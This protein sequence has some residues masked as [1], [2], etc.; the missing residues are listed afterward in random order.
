MFKIRWVWAA[1]VGLAM[2]SV[3]GT[4]LVSSGQPL[5]TDDTWLHWA[6]GRAH[7]HLGPWLPE[8]P[9]LAQALGPPTP[10]A[11][12]FDLGIFGVERTGGFT[13]LRVVHVLF[14]VA[15]LGLA[16]ALYRRARADFLLAGLAMLGFVSLS[17]YRLI[18]LRPHLLTLFAALAL[19]ALVIDRNR[20]P[21]FLRG[22]LAVLLL[23]LWA[24]SH[25]G[26][27]LGFLMLG[28]A[29]LSLIVSL[30][31]RSAKAFQADGPRLRMWWAVGVVG[32]C[33]SLL[34]PA[35]LEPH[36]AWFVAGEE[37][38]SL[39]R[40][41][42]EWVRF[43][44]FRRPQSG[45]PPSPVVWS[46]QWLLM[47][48]TIAAGLYALRSWNQERRE[49]AAGPAIDP[50]LL[51][52]ALLSLALPFIAIRFLWLGIFPLLLF[53]QAE[54]S[55]QE[56]KFSSWHHAR[57]WVLS[58]LSVVLAFAFFQAGPW[59]M[60]R[61]SLPASWTGYQQPYPS[62]KYHAQLIWMA[63]DAGLEGTAFADYHIAN[64][65]GAYLTPNIRMLIN[66]TL[67]VAPDVMN[68]NLP[69]RQRRG[70]REGEAF[71]ELLDRHEID[72]YFGIRLPQSA[73]NSRPRFNTTNHLENVEGWIPIFRNLTG[74]IYLRDHPRNQANLERVSAWYAEEN[75]PFDPE[76][77]FDLEQVI[78]K[79]RPWAIQQGLIPAHFDLMTRAAYG[80]NQATRSRSRANLAAIY[81]ALGLY[82]NALQVDR[83][84][85]A[86]NENAVR[87]RR[88][89]VWSLLQLGRY[90]E[91]AQEAGKLAA[92]PAS[93][94]LSRRIAKAA[95]RVSRETDPEARSVIIAATPVFDGLDVP[96][97]T[98]QLA[99]PPIRP[100]PQ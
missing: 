74:A 32:G 68:A 47:A 23:W 61:G 78:R 91:A 27:L 43:S 7:A 34:N 56:R 76:G 60:M 33:A 30:P 92:Q 19:Y 89:L 9:L 86:E 44:A 64:F 70:Q 57:G 25:A 83:M 39:A 99:M 69:L 97:I 75:V 10:A 88:R 55:L 14:V 29:G 22:V 84:L 59:G 31:F 24:N 26:F 71:Q 20:K 65:A 11:W 100:L 41:A 16:W 53:I 15:I 98:A 81:V 77:G 12:L 51:G 45:L 79:N 80:A 6:L 93:D 5:V 46:L 95:D 54:R 37:T 38:P 18:Q 36:L 49:I 96:G 3:I 50:A 66:G 94:S 52:L 2:W 35:G 73:P 1:L 8:D 17:A 48:T 82:E 63:Q 87:A 28:V 42:D 21:N 67:N 62:G 72:L 90:E 85:L 58:S 13:G 40:V 4:V